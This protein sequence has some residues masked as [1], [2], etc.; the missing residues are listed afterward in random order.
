M[1]AW[2]FLLVC[3]EHLV[4]SSLLSSPTRTEHVYVYM[5][6]VINLQCILIEE[7]W[8]ILDSKKRA[9]QVSNRTTGGEEGSQVPR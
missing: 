3:I 5:V 8:V 4:H 9:R 6:K 7:T 1:Q 2:W